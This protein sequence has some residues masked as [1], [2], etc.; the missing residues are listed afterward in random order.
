MSRFNE[1]GNLPKGWLAF[2]LNV[3]R[4]LK[5]GSV[6]LPF[7]GEPALGVYL[8]RWSIRV[9]GNDSLQSAWTKAIAQIQNNAENLTESQVA[10][11]LEDVYVPRHKLYNA[12]LRNWFSET[13]AWW[14][15]NVRENAEKLES[16]LARAIALTIGMAVGDYVLSFD[17]ETLE[18]RQPLSHVFRRVWSNFPAAVNNQKNNTCFNK[19]ARDFLAEQYG[20]LMFLR[21]PR[22][23]NLSLKASLGFT[24]WR[25]DWVRGTDTFWENFEQ[26]QVGRLGTKVETKYQYLRLVEEI[27]QTAAHIPAWSIT[28]TE[29]GFVTTQ[30]LVE[31]I[32]R[33]RRVDTIYT[34]DFSE[35]TGAKAVIITA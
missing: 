12:S 20:D 9:L 26:Q 2:E 5:F 14:F 16:P 18:F 15:D 34:K 29:D 25:E 6:I 22:A 35:L 23:H 30:E 13:D 4:R 10:L 11:T 1:N 32:N 3:L 24:A 7:T 27:L 21:L 31:T 8:K 28:H 33:V 17:E 19:D